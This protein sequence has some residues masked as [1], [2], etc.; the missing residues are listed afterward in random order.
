MSF[1]KNEFKN[2]VPRKG[3]N[4]AI[5]DDE[6]IPTYVTLRHCAQCFCAREGAIGITLNR[7]KTWVCSGFCSHAYYHDRDMTQYSQSVQFE[8]AKHRDHHE[9]IKKRKQALGL[10]R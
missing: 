7:A 10:P 4:Q 1:N 5:D 9:I 6:K 3:K 2:D 8:I